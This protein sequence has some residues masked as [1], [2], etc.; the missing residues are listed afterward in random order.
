MDE[1]LLAIL[2]DEAVLN[3]I[4]IVGTGLICG[5]IGNIIICIKNRKK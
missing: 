4:L 1:I 2:E 5:I 3:I